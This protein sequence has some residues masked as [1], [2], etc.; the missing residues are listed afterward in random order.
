MW[1]FHTQFFLNYADSVRRHDRTEENEAL[2]GLEDYTADFA[3]F[4]ATATG[5][6][7]PESAVAAM[8]R[9]HVDQLT[10]Q[11]DAYAAGELDTAL[12]RE[13]ES[14][15]YLATIGTALAGAFS[16]QD[17]V[18]FPGPVD[19]AG[20]AYCSILASQLTTLT[21]VVVT[22]AV[23]GG[24]AAT[25]RSDGWTAA[26][27][28]AERQALDSI[29]TQLDVDLSELTD[30]FAQDQ[31]SQ[32]GSALLGAIDR[33]TLEQQA[34][35]HDLSS[36]GPQLLAGDRDGA[37]APVAIR[38]AYATAYRLAAAARTP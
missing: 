11:L 12:A 15:T 35:A 2:A 24:P 29:G 17:P 14:H 30:V 22:T 10:G 21:D 19:G 27:D 34:D 6:A 36:F 32:F 25:D 13:V 31:T 5:D 3:S 1:S 28:E 18:A 7:A 16:T 20:V 38:N 33:P 8:L 26:L 9:Q 23:T 4:L 37:A